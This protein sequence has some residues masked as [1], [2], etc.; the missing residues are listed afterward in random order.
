MLI[1]LRDFTVNVTDVLSRVCVFCCFTNT[2]CFLPECWRLL[3]SHNTTFSAM[4]KKFSF[5]SLPSE[6]CL[7]IH[8]TEIYFLLKYAEFRYKL[9][10]TVFK[11]NSDLPL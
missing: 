2:K 7:A 10:F 5:V 9:K 1:K 6:P 8:N 11:E 3:I 4:R